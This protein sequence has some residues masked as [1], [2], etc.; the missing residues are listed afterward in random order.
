MQQNNQISHLNHM[1]KTNFHPFILL[2]AC[3]CIA[4]QTY[5]Q[6]S[7][8]RNGGFEEHAEL[9]CMNCQGIGQ[10]GSL[11]YNWD[12]GGWHCVLCD[13]DYKQN[14]DDKKGKVCPLDK[15]SPQS[16]KSM[17]SMTYISRMNGVYNGV[18]G[19]S[20]LSARTTE[21]M[22][23]GHLYEVSLWIYAQSGNRHDP[24]W[25]KHLGIA[26]LPQNLSFF[27][28]YEKKSLI[29]P[30]LAV[31][32]LVY[33]QWYQ[34][35]WR[36]RPLCTSNYLMIGI[37]ADPQ[38]PRSH[39][40]NDIQYF[41]DNVA[42]V[43]MPEAS[44]IAD[45]S[46]YYCSRYDPGVLGVR[47]LMDNQILLY[48][49]DA[50]TL[51][52]EHRAVLDSF[53]SYVNQYPDLIFELSGHTDSIGNDN[54]ALSQK[55]VQAVHTYLTEVLKIP[56]YRFYVRAVGGDAPYRPN[57]TEAGRKLNRR[58][59]IRQ[60]NL[61]LEEMFYRA[62]LKAMKENN[63]AT[64]FS[65]LDRWTAK[66]DKGTTVLLLFDP[67]FERLRADKRWPFLEKKVRASYKNLKYGRESF[68]IDS[69]RFETCRYAGEPLAI[70][71]NRLPGNVPGDDPY[72]VEIPGKTDAAVRKQSEQSYQTIYPILQKTG[73][74]K[75]GN[76]S[77]SAVNN[78]FHL[79][80]SSGDIA[81]HLT[82]LPVL[83]QACL[84][85]DLPWKMYAL[86][87]DHTRV[88]LGKP[89]RYL[90]YY[91]NLEDGSVELSPWEGDENTINDW[92]AKI[93]LALLPQAVVEAM[94]VKK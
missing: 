30:F 43:E 92:R 63:V 46:I 64:S 57:T 22:R 9:K 53:A 89:Q 6:K 91:Q 28:G 19:A 48:E 85:G 20:H 27:C 78:A 42:V 35:K 4:S 25:G 40:Y 29:I 10:Y 39:S 56:T 32:T 34:A 2:L 24:D 26:L 70:I 62:A 61:T 88:L 76:Y 87:Y 77:E 65:S 11:V 13:T 75:K 1:Y 12:N 90:L 50:F 8:L 47:P 51:T 33:D 79:L 66:V 44:A 41:I 17:I 16:G 93:G 38:W 86:C 59:E 67:R 60:S 73:W 80:M 74:P 71:L 14:S 84:A 81:A 15:V 5:A 83:E 31:D 37:F 82:W 21:S 52:N 94:R 54:I 68:L 7:I 55:R 72:E 69:L 36:V 45:S 49:N 23:V 3:I 58:T 18:E